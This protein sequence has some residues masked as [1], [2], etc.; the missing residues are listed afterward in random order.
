MEN[1]EPIR[2]IGDEL[3]MNVLFQEG[4]N[5]P[6][7]AVIK[8]IAEQKRAIATLKQD[9]NDKNEQ[10]SALSTQISSMESQLGDLKS[11]EATLSMIMEQQR[12]WREKAAKVEKMFTPD[13]AQVHRTGDNVTIRLYGLNFASGK[14]SIESNYFGLLSKVQKAIDEYPD[15]GITIE[16]H[17]DSFGGDQFN[18]TLSTKRAEA[19]REYFLATAG[20]AA[21]RVVSVGYGETKPIASN[22][23]KEGRRKNRRIDVVLH[24]KK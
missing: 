23:T 6:T 16:G 18:H 13:E 19:V 21:E 7:S 20:I 1:E 14:A 22:E 2:K 4:F 24:P 12:V 17:T 10:I 3:D 9:L 5:K 15:C 11:K 8:R